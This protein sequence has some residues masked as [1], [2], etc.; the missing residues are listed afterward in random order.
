M[1]SIYVLNT[2]LCYCLY[3]FSDMDNDDQ[4]LKDIE[5]NWVSIAKQAVS[6]VI[7]MLSPSTFCGGRRHKL[8]Q[9]LPPCLNTPARLCMWFIRM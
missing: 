8:P 6:F 7:L 5:I 2:F 4:L 1:A 9:N 3:F